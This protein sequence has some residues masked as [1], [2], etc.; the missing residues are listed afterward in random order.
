MRILATADEWRDNQPYWGLTEFEVYGD[1]F[2]DSLVRDAIVYVEV[3]ADLTRPVHSFSAWVCIL[4]A[5]VM[6]RV[7]RP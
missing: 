5:V 2:G 3:G 6:F 4:T 7:V 1:E